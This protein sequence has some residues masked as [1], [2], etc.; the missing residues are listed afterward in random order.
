[1]SA[2]ITLASRCLALTLVA[3]LAACGS[4]EPPA[5]PDVRR[6][7]GTRGFYPSS[8]RA[9]K[10]DVERYVKSASPPAVPGDPKIVIAPH[11]GY[12]FSG[13]TAGHAFKVLRKRGNVKT[14]LLMGC[15]HRVAVRNVSIWPRGA[16]RTP[17]G[18][19]AIDADAAAR[20]TKACGTRFQKS[21]HVRE[22]SLEVE[23]P[24]IQALF[25]K[26]KIVP[27]LVYHMAP[28]VREK[29]VN[30]IAEELK[31]PG[32]VLVVSTDFSHYPTTGRLAEQIDRAA[33][34]SL[35]TLDADRVDKVC[36]GILRKGHPGVGCV[37]CGREA[38]TTALRAARK[39]GLDKGTILHY[40]NSAA[41]LGDGRVVGYG[42][43]AFSKSGAKPPVPKAEPKAPAKEEAMLSPAARKALLHIARES[44]KAAL[45]GRS[46]APPKPK[47]K[48]LLQPGGCFVTLKNHGR[49]R[50]CLGTFATNQPIYLAVARMGAASAT[51]DHRFR[52]NPVTLKE[53]PKIGIEISVLSPRRRIDSWKKIKL[54]KQGVVVRRGWR[55]GV[56]LPQVA[57]ETGWSLEQ[58]LRNLC[59]HKAGLAPDAY[60][61]PRTTLEVFDAEVFGEKK[62]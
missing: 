48:Q 27:I 17:L 37:M 9:L 2:R 8:E 1:M 59:A 14:V 32:T 43:I 26:A 60:K 56:F 30:A 15:P 22:H 35:K 6:P 51:R 31:R 12:V 18:D 25:P 53:L 57:T 61:D 19:C 3:A 28:A 16:Y 11:A 45:E 50:G 47:L 10:A 7:V 33:L 34:Q 5:S 49:L 62:R 20:L 23:V 41:R 52:G 42:A 40:T 44:A 13:A 55:S 21:A 29:L 38:A 24:F 36:N 54:G 46:W 58:F 39:A 4:A